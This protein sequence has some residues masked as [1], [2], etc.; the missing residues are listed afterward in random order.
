MDFFRETRE[1]RPVCK[2]FFF[3]FIIIYFILFWVKNERLNDILVKERMFESP[4]GISFL[5]IH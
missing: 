1:L 2:P 3:F 4:K 5:L